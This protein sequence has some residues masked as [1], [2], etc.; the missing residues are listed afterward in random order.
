MYRQGRFL[1]EFSVLKNRNLG[2]LRT[3]CYSTLL[4]LLSPPDSLPI[5]LRT[6]HLLYNTKAP[7]KP[8]TPNATYAPFIPPSVTRCL[9]AAPV[10]VATAAALVAAPA[11]VD[12]VKVGSE[13]HVAPCAMLTVVI[14]MFGRTG[15]CGKG[16]V[17]ATEVM[18]LTAFALGE[19]DFAIEEDPAGG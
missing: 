14:D 12:R 16:F 18:A 10:K 2:S 4:L 7:A 6:H 5:S 9:A 1:F 13:L 17:V 15:V 11:P 8:T 19:K 3:L